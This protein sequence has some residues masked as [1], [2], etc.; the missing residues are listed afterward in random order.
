MKISSKITYTNQCLFFGQLLLLLFWFSVCF[1]C[2]FFEW[3]AFLY[4]ACGQLTVK[5]NWKVSFH[6]KS[7]IRSFLICWSFSILHST[8]N[9]TPNML[10]AHCMNTKLSLSLSHSLSFSLPLSISTSFSLF[11]TSTWT[12]TQTEILYFFLFVEK[13][14][15]ISRVIYIIIS[16]RFDM[17]CTMSK[18]ILISSALFSD[19][20]GFSCFVCCRLV[21]VFKILFTFII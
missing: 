10:I 14:S 6:R 18:I 12:Q 11:Y 1:S 3:N 21:R 16:V 13:A 17:K 4:T 5:W 15:A 19:C 9:S 8:Q 2:H 7:K 20:P